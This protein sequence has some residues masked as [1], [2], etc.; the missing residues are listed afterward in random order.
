[1][2]AGI[3]YPNPLKLWFWKDGDR[4]VAYQHEYPRHPNGD[5][6]VIGEPV[7]SALLI[8]PANTPNEDNKS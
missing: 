3:R 4:F 6:L 5:P 7:G 1:M 8:W 2:S